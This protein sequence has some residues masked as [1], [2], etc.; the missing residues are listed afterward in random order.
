MKSLLSSFGEY[1]SLRMIRDKMTGLSKGFAFVDY[2]DPVSFNL[3][4]EGFCFFICF[5][6]FVF[7]FLFFFG[8]IVLCLFPSFLFWRRKILFFFF[9]LCFFLFLKKNNITQDWME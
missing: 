3:A 6:F 2:F 9:V 4:Y 7:C 1:K 5:L 8:L